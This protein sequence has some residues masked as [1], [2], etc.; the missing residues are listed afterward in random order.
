MSI[1]CTHMTLETEV[2]LFAQCSIE[3][4]PVAV[5]SQLAKKKKDDQYWLFCD[6]PVWYFRD[7]LMSH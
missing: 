4:K 7:V 6:Y 5:D 2:K 1:F 3:I